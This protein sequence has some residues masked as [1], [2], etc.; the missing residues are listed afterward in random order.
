MLTRAHLDAVRRYE[1]ERVL[2][3]VPTPRGRLLEI[4]AAGGFQ[5]QL[6]APHFAEVEAIDLPQSIP[7]GTK[8]FPVEPYDGHRLPFP[9]RS[10]DLV[11]SSNVLE[12]IA[13]VSDERWDLDQRGGGEVGAV[14]EQIPG[15]GEGLAEMAA[16]FRGSR[17]SAA[18]YFGAVNWMA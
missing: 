8:A 14:D 17:R 2:A 16:A 13:H 9:D 11:F 5:A 10:F 1:S 3:L 18:S 4:G 6:L 7:A 15:H 12:H